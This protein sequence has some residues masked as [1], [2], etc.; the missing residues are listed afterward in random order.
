MTDSIDTRI[1]ALARHSSQLRGNHEEL[2][3]RIRRGAR[4]TGE[5]HGSAYAEALKLIRLR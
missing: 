2:A 1:A 4:E 5:P 3:E